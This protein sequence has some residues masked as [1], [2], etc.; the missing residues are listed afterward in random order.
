M[1]QD[2]ID[3]Y[4]LWLKTR[5]LTYPR[6][7]VLPTIHSQPDEMAA[8]AEQPP[9]T[10]PEVQ[11]PAP[12]IEGERAV[13]TSVQEIAADENPLDKAKELLEL[14][15]SKDNT[16]TEEAA[17]SEESP[18]S[19]QEVRHALT[20]RP[21]LFLCSQFPQG[22][23]LQFLIKFMAALK[24]ADGEFSIIEEPRFERAFEFLKEVSS[25]EGELRVIMFSDQLSSDQIA[26]AKP[27]SPLFHWTEFASDTKILP[28]MDFNHFVDTP[29][30]KKTLWQA[31]KGFVD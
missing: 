30:Y 14:L 8:S 10:E 31:V 11:I 15:D 12:E 9:T 18:A 17:P 26:S 22:A 5:G 16:R 6:L 24:I 20:G 3:N 4:L 1:L 25:A 29:V 27:Q 19:S 13:E 7:A 2:Q 28:A 21:W 23:E